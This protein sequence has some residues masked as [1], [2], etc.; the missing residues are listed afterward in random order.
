MFEIRPNALY[1]RSDLEAS[2]SEMGVDVDAFISRIK[3]KRI[4][5]AVY[6]GTDLIDAIDQANP[7]QGLSRSRSRRMPRARSR[8]KAAAFTDKEL[9]IA[10]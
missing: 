5:K 4:S 3:P 6:W 9:G 2:F 10:K 8:G 1:T 7:I